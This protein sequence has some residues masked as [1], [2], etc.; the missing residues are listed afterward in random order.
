MTAKRNRSDSATSAVAAMQAAA[1][2]AIKPPSFVNIRKA[3]KPF[4][5]SIVRARARNSWTDSDLVMAGN[6]ARCLSDI[7]RLQKEIDIE[8]DVIANERKT[9]VI[10]PKHSLLETL[11]RRAVA[12]SRTLQVHAQATQGDSRDQGKKATKQRAAEKV[13]AEQ[14]DD[15]LIPRAMH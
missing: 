14:D 3:D 9:Q 4:W 8:G 12:L 10:N 1:A 2:G 7:E 6:L 5:D 11:S 13:L 15:D